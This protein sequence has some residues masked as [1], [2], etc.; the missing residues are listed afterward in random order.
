MGL[1]G[2]LRGTPVGSRGG[3]F[4]CFNPPMY[5]GWGSIFYSGLSGGSPRALGWNA[6]W[7]PLPLL[8]EPLLKF[9]TIAPIENYKE[10]LTM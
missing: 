4:Y 5:L 2:R 7:G 9:L 10:I 1:R 3:H 6:V 8:E